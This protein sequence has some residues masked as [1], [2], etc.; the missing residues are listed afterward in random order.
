MFGLSIAVAAFGTISGW[1]SYE[2]SLPSQQE[3]A[4]ETQA[5][6]WQADG[7][8]NTEVT[9]ES[10]SGGI[11]IAWYTLATAGIED[12]WKNFEYRSASREL[13]LRPGERQQ[14]TWTES[15][16][17]PSGV[18]TQDVWFQRKVGER[19]VNVG[20]A[21]GPTLRRQQTDLRS[22]QV[23]GDSPIAL[24]VHSLSG[25]DSALSFFIDVSCVRCEGGVGVSWSLVNAADQQQAHSSTVVSLTVQGSAATGE[26]HARPL[27]PAGQY[28]LKVVATEIG[29]D[30]QS[31]IAWLRSAYSVD[32]DPL[33]IRTAEPAGPYVWVLTAPL[34]DVRP[35]AE[36][37]LSGV[38]V[39][40]ED[41]LPCR[42]F[43]QITDRGQQ[44][45]AS[46]SAECNRPRLRVP[47]IP[48]G[49]YELVIAAYAEASTGEGGSLSDLVAI[50][51]T[52]K[53]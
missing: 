24:A 1:P 17:L 8:L 43:W 38:Q 53:E 13:R 46:G 44:V 2:A 51:L 19:N 27:V 5:V 18:F 4:A 32:Q 23:N 25:L 40:G 28:D 12:S 3:L 31:Q 48:A 37:V 16:P 15:V 42:A 6:D 47:T 9:V 33:M 39:N 22:F 29:G 7:T 50:P 21:A 45:L 34:P 10:A 52:V 41:P 30:S 36:V 11:L 49:S 14:V 26:I 35:G 20:T